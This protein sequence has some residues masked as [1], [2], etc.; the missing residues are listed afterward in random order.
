MTFLDDPFHI[1]HSVPANST[2]ND[3]CGWPR[4]V[5]GDLDGPACKCGAVMVPCQE[6]IN[7]ELKGESF[8]CLSCGTETRP[9]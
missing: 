5:T 1:W 7:G 6:L 2:R 4:E 9:S 8:V 3:E